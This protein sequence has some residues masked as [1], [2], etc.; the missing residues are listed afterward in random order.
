MQE[1]W[2]TGREYIRENSY[3]GEFTKSTDLVSW[4]KINLQKECWQNSHKYTYMWE[5]SIT[6]YNGIYV[7]R[8]LLYEDIRETIAQ[9]SR[10]G[11]PR[12]K[13]II[14]LN[15]QF[16]LLKIIPFDNSI[17]DFSYVNGRFYLRTQDY[18][19]NFNESYQ[20]IN[21]I[22]VS[23]DAIN[24]SIEP[25][26]S[27]VPL[28]NG[29]RNILTFSNGVFIGEA[30]SRVQNYTMQNLAISKNLTDFKNVTFENQ[31]H[32]NYE[33]AND[34]Y[35]SYPKYGQGEDMSSFKAS[36]DGVYW[37]EILFPT[38]GSYEDIRL[39]IQLGDKIVFQTNQKRLLEY[40]INELKQAM[41]N[42]GGM[43]STYVQIHN[44]ILGFDTLPV[45]ESDHSGGC[46]CTN[47]NLWHGTG[48]ER[49]CL[50]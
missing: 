45:M 25:T 12:C 36:L 24:W 17:T 34:I 15:D 41:L 20:P 50:D 30:Y 14:I 26:L 13:D 32:I 48:K 43:D 1:I 35:I 10:N 33:V 18:K 9:L 44:E 8:D 29:L 22:Y 28:A 37:Y 23:D 11:D 27:E 46:Q 19:T 40:D 6:Y 2:W 31:P 5:P 42:Q 3:I 49:V 4:E 47:P 38:I 7:V 21:T 16:E 39:Y